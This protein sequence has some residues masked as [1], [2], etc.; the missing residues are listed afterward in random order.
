MLENVGKGGDEELSDW[1][2]QGSRPARAL[3]LS[4]SHPWLPLRDGYSSCAIQMRAVKRMELRD[5]CRPT[6]S[7]LGVGSGDGL[8]RGVAALAWVVM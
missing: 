1:W 4:W 5:L 8:G 2:S 7:S 3:L 6:L